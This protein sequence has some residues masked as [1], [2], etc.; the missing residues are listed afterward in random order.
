M[1]EKAPKTRRRF[2]ADLLFLGGGVTAASLLARSTLLDSGETTP[3]PASTPDVAIEK[4]FP[5]S[6]EPMAA[7]GMEIPDSD[8]V[9]QKPEC[10]TQT[11]K[12]QKPQL[13]ERDPFSK[14]GDEAPPAV[15]GAIAIPSKPSAVGERRLPDQE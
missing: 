1:S 4:P 12:P 15:R 13:T 11:D 2:L 14:D 9:D 7:G 3:A 10:E 5:L 6:D 8:F